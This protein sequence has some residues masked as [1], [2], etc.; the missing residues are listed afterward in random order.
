MGDSIEDSSRAAQRAQSPDHDTDLHSQ[1]QR[2]GQGTGLWRRLVNVLQPSDSG[3]EDKDTPGLPDAITAP[4]LG[5]LSELSVEDVSIPKADIVSVP[6]NITKDDL[7]KTFR[8]SGLTRLPVYDGT[9]D[10]PAGF[11]HLK[12]FALKHGFNG[13]GGRFSLK[14]MLRPLMFVP[15]SMPI[16][17]LLQK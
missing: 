4:G 11:I 5:N 2:N 10:S 7:V 9:I 12:D 13:G 3:P 14:K 17:V 16:G 15:P 8:D 6:L 1:S